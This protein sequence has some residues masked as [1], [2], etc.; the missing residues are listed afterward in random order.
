MFYK[1]VFLIDIKE[2]ENVSGFNK[3]QENTYKLVLEEW[4]KREN[5]L[6]NLLLSDKKYVDPFKRDLK[7]LE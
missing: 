5:A 7:E 6:E 4:E 1:Y 2:P 3:F